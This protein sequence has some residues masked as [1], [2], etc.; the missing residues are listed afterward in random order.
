MNYNS[1]STN[2]PTKKFIIIYLVS[3]QPWPSKIFS[4][5]EAPLGPV[6]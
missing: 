3:Y 2:S 1:G 6:A 5:I 4:F